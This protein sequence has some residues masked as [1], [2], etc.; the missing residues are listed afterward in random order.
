MTRLPDGL[1]PQSPLLHRSRRQ[2]RRAGLLKTSTVAL[3]RRFI[4][5][6]EAQGDFIKE[7]MRNFFLLLGDGYNHTPPWCCKYSL[8]LSECSEPAES[9]SFLGEP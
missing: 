4:T 6:E 1:F 5:L 7:E 9:Y 2:H 8:L 3:A